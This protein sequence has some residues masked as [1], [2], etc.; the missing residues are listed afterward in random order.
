[1]KIY[2]QGVL[3]ENTTEDYPHMDR[4]RAAIIL[5]RRSGDRR[6]SGDDDKKDFKQPNLIAEQ[7]MLAAG[8]RV[9]EIPEPIATVPL[10]SRL[11]HDPLQG[12]VFIRPEEL[13]V[14]IDMLL[15]AQT[16]SFNLDGTLLSWID[17]SLVVFDVALR[18]V[19]AQV[20]AAA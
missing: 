17:E 20:S 2:R 12:V 15:K 14:G 9:V 19:E 7:A 16:R 8:V 1:M 11:L 18:S 6:L 5:G 10:E 4:L 13:K 3:L